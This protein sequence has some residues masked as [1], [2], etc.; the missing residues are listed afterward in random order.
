MGIL[1]DGPN[2][3][4]R[5]KVGSVYGYELNGKWILRGAR[6]KSSKPPTADQLS[7]RKKTKLNGEFCKWIKPIITFG[8]QFEAAKDPN[9]GAFQLAQKHVFNHAIELDSMGKP[10]I[11][12][13]KLRVFVGEL[14]APEGVQVHL[15][16]DV[17]TLSWLPNPE[18]ND[19]VFKLNLALVS[20]DDPV[21]L[22]MAIA[23]AAQGECAIKISTLKNRKSDYHV[24][25]GFWDTYHGVFS[26]S[27]YCGVI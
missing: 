14:G 12:F 11:I 5:G 23:D 25:I 4:F 21:D 16:E 26:N 13:E 10:C 9:R 3:G 22:K 6:K 24:Y 7:H 2:G 19:S 8:Y 17:L 15:E 1:Q 18:Y 27:A 20:P